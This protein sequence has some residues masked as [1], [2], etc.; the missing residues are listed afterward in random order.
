MQ[1]LLTNIFLVV[2][3]CLTMWSCTQDNAQSLVSPKVANLFNRSTPDADETQYFGIQV[4]KIAKTRKEFSYGYS[5]IADGLYKK[6]DYSNALIFYKKVDSISILLNDDDRRFMTNMFMTRIYNKVGLLSR[7]DESLNL[8]N[9][10][11]KKS[12]IP[13]SHYYL[14]NAETNLL[15]LSY[16]YCE[17]IPKRKELL[18]QILKISNQKEEDK[19]ILVGSYIQLAYNQIKC[20]QLS[21]A[22]L[23][24]NKADNLIRNDHYINN[25]III[26]LYKMVKGIY[27]A[28]VNDYEQAAIYFDEALDS[29]KKNNLNVDRIKVLK[30]RINYNFD[31]F[32]VRKKMINE[33][34]NLEVNRKKQIGKIIEQEIKYKNTIIR[35]KE[36]YQIILLTISLV[37]LVA[38]F[39]LIKVSANRRKI[40]NKNFNHIL[41]Q[42]QE[43]N[44]ERKENNTAQLLISQP[45]EDKEKNSKDEELSGDNRN[46]S[47][48][49]ILSDKKEMDLL[50]KLKDFEAGKEFLNNNFSISSMAA[51]FDTNSKYINFILQKHRNKT[52]SDYI[53]SLRILYI[54][55]LLYQKTEYRNYKISYL[56]EVCGYS[57]HSRFTSVFKAETGLSPSDFIN[58]ISNKN[59]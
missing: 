27:S 16:K 43:K 56:A 34:N 41:S 33:L 11:V 57:S 4:L 42:L 36:I 14:L 58:K 39:I 5:L 30:E 38:I 51:Q 23:L 46:N 17:A 20:G 29:A 35:E 45:K 26:A 37:L 54:T 3:L 31:S 52:F 13:Y 59:P 15:E 44:L 9:T 53:N 55:K 40:A 21:E 18:G 19:S 32:H 10:L 24:I 49:K 1:V 48:K 2:I 47:D 6:E 8:C 50:K 22:G 25:T 12:V 28:E 7:A